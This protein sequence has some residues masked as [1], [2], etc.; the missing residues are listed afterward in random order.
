M[1]IQYKTRKLEKILTNERLIKKNYASFYRN[2]CNRLSELR[3][4]NNLAEIPDFPPPRRHKLNGYLDN[5][6]G[7]DISKNFRIILKPIGIFDI[8]R[9][10][11]I[12]EIEI[13]SLEDY[14]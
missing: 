10:D 4:A 5:H 11:T 8:E 13:I 3:A 6:W 14:H 12:V 7:I 9:L 2:V 1:K